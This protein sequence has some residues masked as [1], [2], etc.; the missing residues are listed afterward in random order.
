M[1]SAFV[2]TDG[3]GHILITSRAQTLGPIGQQIDV[4]IMGM[5]EG[6]LFLLRRTRCIAQNASLDQATD[7][8]LAGAEAIIIAMDFLPL[9]LD[10]AGAYIDEVGCDFSIYL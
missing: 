6:T 3:P 5:M 2:P 7:E 8:Q 1:V 4:N 9:A 10:Q